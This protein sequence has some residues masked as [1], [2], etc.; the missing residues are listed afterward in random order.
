MRSGDQANVQ[1]A[2][3]NVTVDILPNVKRKELYERPHISKEIG[4][5]IK[6]LEEADDDRRY[7]NYVFGLQQALEKLISTEE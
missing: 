6:S 7:T 5:V 3:N 1:R 2:L 4:K